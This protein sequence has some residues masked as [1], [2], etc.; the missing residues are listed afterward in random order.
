MNL[1]NYLKLL[2]NSRF[3]QIITIFFFIL[4]FV[5]GLNIYKDYGLSNDEPF[6]RSVGYFWY[7]HLLENFS[8]NVEIINEIKQK[9]QSMYWSNYLNE[10]NLNQYGILFDTLAAILEE[11]FNIN[12]NREA[13]F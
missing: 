6:Q 3:Q 2:S 4:F 5:I 9:F 1:N 8:N 7:I 12:E 10:G 13:F 11:L